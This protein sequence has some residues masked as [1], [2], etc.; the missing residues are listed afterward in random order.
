M[1]RRSSA[2]LGWSTEDTAQMAKLR[3]VMVD[4]Y[5]RFI[6]AIAWVEAAGYATGAEGQIASASPSRAPLMAPDKLQLLNLDCQKLGLFERHPHALCTLGQLEVLETLKLR[7]NVLTALPSEIGRLVRLRELWLTQNHLC[8]LPESFGNLSKLQ[9]LALER[10]HL[11]R[12]PSCLGKLRRLL[13]LGLDEQE[14]AMEGLV[15][16]P[17][18]VLSILRGRGCQA[19]FPALSSE[20]HENPNLNTVFWANN[21]LSTVPHLQAFAQSL[22]LLDLAHNRIATVGDEIFSLCNLRDLSLAGNVLQDLPRSIGRMRCLQQLWLHGNSLSQLPDELGDLESLAILE[23]HHN[24][25]LGLPSS[26]FGLQKLNWFFA[27][28]NRLTDPRIVKTLSALP[29]IKIVGLGSNKLQL[30]D[31]DFRKLGRASFGLG[32]N[33]GVQSNP[34]LTEALTTTE[35]HWD[36]M[37][38]EIQDV[39]VVTFSAQGAPVAQGQAEVRALRDAFL[40]VDALYVCDPANAW[41]LQDPSQQWRGLSWLGAS[42]NAR[43]T[44]T[45]PEESP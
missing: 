12:L 25:L 44:S 43:L 41:F 20:K 10:N 14:T 15:V 16:V 21:G 3:T 23:L 26:L 33:L 2:L 39:L 19:P 22:R 4:R 17:A 42:W 40:K 13:Q 45:C 34:V 30:K 1:E 11:A 7:R 27:H 24:R 5:A 9:V 37:E 35:L 36:K 31:L 32:W 8:D 18:A 28:G 38:D 6:A 29:R